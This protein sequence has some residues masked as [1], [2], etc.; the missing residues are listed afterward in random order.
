MV[1]VIPG[2]ADLGQVARQGRLQHLHQ[3]LPRQLLHP[4][5]LGTHIADFDCIK[6]VLAQEA[7]SLLILCHLPI[8]R[9]LHCALAY[10]CQSLCM[11]LV[12]RAAAC[13]GWCTS[14]GV[15][16]EAVVQALP[17]RFALIC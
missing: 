2:T 9:F 3:K 12:K 11:L 1:Q 10:V 7:R 4:A 16:H 8:A 6:Y 5:V 17:D 14:C 15:C 13:L